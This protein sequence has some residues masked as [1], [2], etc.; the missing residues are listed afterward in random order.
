MVLPTSL[1]TLLSETTS[2]KEDLQASA[3]P[4]QVACL[5][6]AEDVDEWCDSG[7]DP[8]GP[9]SVPPGGLA[10]GSW[11]LSWL[12]LVFGHITEEGDLALHLVVI[13]QHEPFLDFLLGLRPGPAR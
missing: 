4:R 3:G 13:H 6:K 7:L 11:G 2:P 10:L 8:L 5:G 9:D 12:P 1:G